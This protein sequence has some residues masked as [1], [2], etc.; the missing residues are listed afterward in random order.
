MAS[1]EADSSTYSGVTIPIPEFLISFVLRVI[2]DAYQAWWL[3]L[4]HENPTHLYIETTLV[5]LNTY[6]LIVHSH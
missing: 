1:Q 4:L 5:R 2:P 6:L 3:N